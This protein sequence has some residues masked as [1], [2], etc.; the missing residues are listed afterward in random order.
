MSGSLE[1]SLNKASAAEIVDHLR[2]CD[3][4]FMPALSDRVEISPYAQ[5]LVRKASRF[6]AWSDGRLVGL[7]AIYCNDQETR[8]AYIT[9]VSVL[10]AWI[11]KGIAFDLMS[12]G[13]QHAKDSGMRK[14][15]LD[16]FG[17]QKPAIKLYKKLG[18][19]MS[20]TGGPSITMSLQLK[21]RENNGR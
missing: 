1:L 15:C 5:K 20:K 4:D 7:V 11:G 16:V 13:I 17:K 18:F 19:V 8:S 21:S 12:Q 9:S 6:E 10:R 2:R 14:I 3:T